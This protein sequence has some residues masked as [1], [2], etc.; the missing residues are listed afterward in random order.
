M[1]PKQRGNWNFDRLDEHQKVDALHNPL[2]LSNGPVFCEINAEHVNVSE[3]RP[4]DAGGDVLRRSLLFL[5]EAFR[6]GSDMERT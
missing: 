5:P 1:N 6:K 2:R 4:E 3:V